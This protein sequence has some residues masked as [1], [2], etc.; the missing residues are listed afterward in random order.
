MSNLFDCYYQ[1]GDKKFLNIWQAFDEQFKTQQVPELILDKDFLSSISNLKK[2]KNLS[3]TYIKNLIVQRLKNLRKKYKY[4]RLALGG[5]TDSFSI[6]KYC[7]ENDIYLDEVF[8]HMVSIKSNIKSDIEYLP[9]LMYAEKYQGQQIGNV[10]R[11]HPIINEC[12]F[13][14]QNGWY[15]NPDF[16][17][18]NH[19]PVRPSIPN[20]YYKRSNLPLNESVTIFGFDKPYVIN[21]Q[22]KLYWMQMDSGLGEIM[23][24]ENLLPLFF[25]KENPELTVSLTYALLEN[26]NN[27]VPFIG[28]D[29]QS[30]ENKFKILNAMGLEST[31]HYF[32]DHH[33]L[34]KSKYEYQNKKNRMYHKELQQLG[35]QDIIKAYFRTHKLIILQYQS[36]PHAIEILDNTIVK[37]VLRQSKKIPIFQDSFGA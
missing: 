6:L 17:R 35:R 16:I 12:E 23:G 31:G 5:G 30:K 26:S 24:C 27:S 3:R 8:T 10:V 20:Q 19:L 9:A 29:L 36:L 14:L 37:S 15:K 13:P 33:L 28:Y 2:P 25:D 1:C 34:G 4:L 11:I 21:E 32:I 22:G 18:G 7:V